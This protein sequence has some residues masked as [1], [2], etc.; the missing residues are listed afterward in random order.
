MSVR[1]SLPKE[2]LRGL[3]DGQMLVEL[4]NRVVREFRTS[5][6]KGPSKCNSYWAGSDLLVV[7]LRGGYTV[8]DQTLSTPAR[9]GPSTTRRTPSRTRWSAG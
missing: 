9:S 4:S 7:L 5:V 2:Q 1:E 6:G 3:S 8:A